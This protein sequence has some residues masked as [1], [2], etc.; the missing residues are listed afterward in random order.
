MGVLGAFVSADDRDEYEDNER[1][2][3]GMGSAIEEK[4]ASYRVYTR[5][6]TVTLARGHHTH[7]QQNTLTVKQTQTHSVC[8]YCTTSTLKI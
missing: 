5:Y 7:T 8:I 4:Q 3:I 2:E 1:E 6:G